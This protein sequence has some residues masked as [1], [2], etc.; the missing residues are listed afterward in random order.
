VGPGNTRILAVDDDPGILRGTVRL[1]EG[2]GY[3]VDQASSGEEALGIIGKDRPD[4]V[5]LDRQLPGIDGIETCRR[6]KADPASA[7][8]FVVILSGVWTGSDTQAEGLELGADGYIARPIANRELLARVESYSRIMRLS[9]SLL[10]TVQE[11]QLLIDEIQHRIKNSFAMISSLIFIASKKFASTGAGTAFSE[12]DSRVRSLSELYIML[13]FGEGFDTVRL[14]HYCARVAASIP[15]MP[16]IE[17]D[18][19][20]EEATAKAKTAASI[21]LILTELVTNSVK[22]AFP[23]GRPGRIEVSLARQDGALL[24]AVRDDGGGLPPGFDLAAG[25]GI[26]LRLVMGLAAQIGAVF[27]IESDAGGTRSSLRLEEGSDGQS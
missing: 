8:I 4:L 1:L 17:L 11:K 21:G 10:A 19:R 27:S 18:A 7:G 25:S 16:Q 13:E 3:Q 14:D 6:I 2:A 24:L 12:L 26:G 22:Y 9:R 5:L 23:A 20:L 15:R